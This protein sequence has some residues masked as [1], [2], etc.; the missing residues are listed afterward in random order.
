MWKH[1]IFDKLIHT[2]M[3]L[4]QVNNVTDFDVLLQT[5]YYSTDDLLKFLNFLYKTV[6]CFRTGLHPTILQVLSVSQH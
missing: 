3:I 6:L 2:P 1:L 5:I 4:F